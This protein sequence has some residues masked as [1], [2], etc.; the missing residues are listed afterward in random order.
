MFWT[1]M[2][3][4]LIGA[5]ERSMMTIAMALIRDSSEAYAGHRL[6]QV[7]HITTCHVLWWC[8]LNCWDAE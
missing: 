2:Q 1:T 8:N 7:L 4:N 6:S 3:E 5:G